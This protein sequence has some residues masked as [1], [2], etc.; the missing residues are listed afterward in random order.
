MKKA[1][2]ILAL[3]LLVCEMGALAQQNLQL[4]QYIFS[5][6]TINPAYAGY[7]DAFYLNAVYRHQWQGF[8]G[9]PRDLSLTLDGYVNTERTLAVGAQFLSDKLGPYQTSKYIANVATTVYFDKKLKNRGLSGGLG[10]GAQQH[11]IDQ[12]MLRSLDPNDPMAQ[13]SNTALPTTLDLSFGV[14]Y[15]SERFYGGL[16]LLNILGQHNLVTATGQELF[17]DGVHMY[18]NIGGYFPINERVGFKPF[19]VYKEDFQSVSSFDLVAL[20]DLQHKFWLGGAYQFGTGGRNIPSINTSG[21]SSDH[22]SIILQYFHQ[23][24]YRLGYSY[25]IMVNGLSPY[26]S[27]SHELS[28]GIYLKDPNKYKR[29][30]GPRLF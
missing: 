3:L 10:I 5:P 26:Q 15:F 4:T 2:Y 28:L 17:Q 23:G 6:L 13:L 20:F 18:L 22:A 30:L 25:D 7:R 16:A 29:L 14:Y 1:K 24:K 9:A 12:G 11:S 21:F 8:E 27:G 19:V